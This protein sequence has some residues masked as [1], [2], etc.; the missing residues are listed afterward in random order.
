MS[1]TKKASFFQVIIFF[2][3]RGKD[4]KTDL[5]HLRDST[6]QYILLLSLDLE[7]MKSFIGLD[8]LN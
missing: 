5:I 7:G 2:E 3:I 6:R 4:N 8:F 1:F